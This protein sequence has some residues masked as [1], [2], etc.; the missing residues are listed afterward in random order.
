MKQLWMQISVCI[1]TIHGFLA[2]STQRGWKGSERD[3]V[4]L[5]YEKVVR[6]DI[7]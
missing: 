5:Y 7:F 2:T 4:N 6:K 3:R 1:Y